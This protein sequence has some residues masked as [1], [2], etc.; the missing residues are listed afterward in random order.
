MGRGD[1]YEAVRADLAA[2]DQTQI[3]RGRLGRLGYR[4]SDRPGG[5]E[6]APGEARSRGWTRLVGRLIVNESTRS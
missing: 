3:D 1:G 4:L 2:D 6:P 5:F